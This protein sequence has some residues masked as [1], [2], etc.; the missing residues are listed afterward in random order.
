MRLGF[1][2]SLSLGAILAAE[3]RRALALEVDEDEQKMLSQ[4]N[5]EVDD[6]EFFNELVQIKNENED[7]LEYD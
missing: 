2:T 3:S 5:W 7:K 4:L 6:D 1:Y